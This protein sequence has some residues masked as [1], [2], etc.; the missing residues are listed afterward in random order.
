MCCSSSAGSVI[1]FS[2][3]GIVLDLPGGCVTRVC[4]AVGCLIES[5][6]RR[7]P[8]QHEGGGEVECGGR[9]GQGAERTQVP[10]MSC[11]VREKTFSHLSGDFFIRSRPHC[12][13]GVRWGF[14]Q[15]RLVEPSNRAPPI[16]QVS[17]GYRHIFRLAKQ[18][19]NTLTAHEM[20]S[21]GDES[22]S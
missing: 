1:K 10:Y 13:I 15:K 5:R 9:S 4:A 18:P 3:S 22:T 14:W 7:R 20:Q 12:G 17:R 21:S 16:G 2:R 11:G 8:R 19:G 6:E